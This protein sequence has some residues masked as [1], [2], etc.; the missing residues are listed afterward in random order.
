MAATV[1]RTFRGDG[2]LMVDA[3]IKASVAHKVA[4]DSEPVK[5]RQLT[6]YF[7]P[8]VAE[9]DLK[10]INAAL[11]LLPA[12]RRGPA[13]WALPFMNISGRRGVTCCPR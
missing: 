8:G 1:N 10:H 4:A 9:P 7:V 2:E 11:D 13:D 3:L 12:P 6:P 5:T